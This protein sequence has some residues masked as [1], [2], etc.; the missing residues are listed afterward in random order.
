MNDVSIGRL[1]ALVV[2]VVKNRK[3]ET[4]TAAELAALYDVEFEAGKINAQDIQAQG[5][6]RLEVVRAQGAYAKHRQRLE[7]ALR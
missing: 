2:G 1:A 3:V 7:N 4:F 6:T 5:L